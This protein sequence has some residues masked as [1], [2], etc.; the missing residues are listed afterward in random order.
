M[1]LV[2]ASGFFIPQHVLGVVDYF[3]GLE[4]HIKKA[5]KH[6]ACFPDVGA[7][8][9]CEDRAK[10][11]AQGIHK[12]FPDGEIH[13][14]AHSMGGLDSRMLIERN[15]LGLSGRIK[16]L[17]TVATPHFGSPAADLV[18]GERPKEESIKFGDAIAGVIRFLGLADGALRDLT[19]KG[20]A[21]TPDPRQSHPGIRY[22]SYA[23]VGRPAGLLGFLGL[24]RKKTA[25]AFLPTHGYLES[26]PDGGEN[27]GVVPFRSAQYGEFQ[28]DDLWQCDHADA[29]G[30][31]LDTPIFGFRFKHLDA[32]DAII[33][34]L[35][36]DQSRP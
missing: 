35:E 4:D 30:Y 26:V 2:F 8:D 17:T 13:I 20:A 19:T 32:Y 18:L 24:P 7:L 14:I 9:R 1:N 28:Q 23:A 29:M 10:M 16:S 33:R 34:Q 5:G 12:T 15:H 25:A 3:R 21:A 36:N 31:N 6:K 11:L 27:D 22:R